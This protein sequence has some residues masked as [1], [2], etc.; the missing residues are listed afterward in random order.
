MRISISPSY[1]VT[2]TKSSATAT[3]TIMEYEMAHQQQESKP[4]SPTQPSTQTII[5]KSYSISTERKTNRKYVRKGANKWY[6]DEHLGQYR[7]VNEKR[8]SI[9]IY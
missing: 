5:R 9:Y 4:T 1:S 7:Y 6:L 2:M 8:S 3:T